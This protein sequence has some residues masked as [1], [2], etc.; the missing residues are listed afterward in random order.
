MHTFKSKKLTTVLAALTAVAMLAACGSDPAP[1]PEDNTSSSSSGGE[2]DGNVAADG[3]SDTGAEDSGSSS[4]GDDAGPADASSSGGKDAGGSSGDAGP[5]DGGGDDKDAGPT[6]PD[7]T[8][9]GAPD[10]GPKK[11]LPLPDC[12]KKGAVNCDNCPE[13]PMC[14]DGQNYKNDCEAILALKAYDWPKGYA[15]QQGACPKCKGCIGVK[16]QC[17]TQKGECEECDSKGCT[18]NGDSC[19]NETDCKWTPV[20][21]KEQGKGWQTFAKPCEAGCEAPLD[22]TVGVNPKYGACKSKCS[23]PPANGG[24]GCAMN[25]Y[26]PVCSKKDGKT[27]A[28]KCAM[29]NCAKTGCFY[30]GAPDK[31]P[32]SKECTENKMELE[33][34]G[35]CWDKDK[36]EWKNCTGECKPVCGI[37]KS[38]KGVNFR[39]KCVADAEG[40][41][42]SSCD[43]ISATKSDKCSAQLYID[44]GAP[45]CEEVQYEILK[46]V[47]A[48]LGQGNDA[49]WFTFR[50]KAE[51]NCWDAKAKADGKKDPKAK[52]WEFKYLGAC[53]CKCNKTDKA[54]CGADGLTYQNACQAKCY[55]DDSFT[56]KDGACK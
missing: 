49:E 6:D 41:K 18:G 33:C 37:V 40:A 56:W 11:V 29:Q 43:G 53:I 45:C 8:D 16:L 4:G 13:T 12:A 44:N 17:N 55:N 42:V 19:Q 50:S 22:K 36:P 3:E 23:S 1:E 15:P 35:A 21:A 24:G 25:V 47:C 38:G 26:Q 32:A 20:C 52:Q 14:L 2:N 46:P 34:H 30:L 28:S 51:F 39:N 27:Y 54:V 10:T 5:V 31:G 48:A 9:A 7:T